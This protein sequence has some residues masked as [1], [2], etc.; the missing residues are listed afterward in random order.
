MHETLIVIPSSRRAA[1]QTTLSYLR[2]AGVL[3][4]TL[5]VVPE[6]QVDNYA[7]WGQECELVPVPRDWRIARKRQFILSELSLLRGASRVLMLDDDLD[8]YYRPDPARWQLQ[9]ARDRGHM[10][11]ILGQLDTWL[12][13]GIVHAGLAARQGSNRV[14]E[15]Y[16][17]ATRMMQVYAYDVSI[18][19]QLVGAGDVVLGRLEVMEDFDLTLQL[20]RLGYPNRVS[21]QYC[22]GQKASGT[23]GG[24]SAW[25]TS[26]VQD[27]AAHGLAELHPG[28]VRV[29]EKK[30]KS[31]WR[32]GLETR[33]DVVVSWAK[34][35]EEGT[36]GVG[37]TVTATR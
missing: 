32:G 28:L 17:D 1:R 33:T 31:G 27:A 13:S 29:T 5:L 16:R 6:D 34:A 2:T 4:R 15:P 37:G 35:Y 26:T 12:G 25:R 21:Y 36:G 11:A 10:L 30:S 8:F 9:Y 3:D 14:A 18:L 20:L 24:C 19:R 7:R 23:E 22:Q